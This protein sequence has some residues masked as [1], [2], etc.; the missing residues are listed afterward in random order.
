MK[1]KIHRLLT[2]PLLGFM[3]LC[4]CHPERPVNDSF[5]DQVLLVENNP[6]LYLAKVDTTK[7]ASVSNEQEAT[8]FLLTALAQNYLNRD[9]YP[10]KDKLIASIR[11]FEKQKLAQQQLEALFLLAP[12]YKRENDLTNEVHTIE[13]AIR[14][15]REEDDQ[16]WLF[17]LY[18]YLGDMYIRQYN[19]LKFVKY[20]TLAN[21][22]IKDI[23]FPD[24]SLATQV[25]VA[26]SLLYLEQYPKAYERLQ[27]IE[28][29]IGKNN[30][31]F[32]DIK[33]LQGI[34]LFQMH[35][36]DACIKD[37]ETSLAGERSAENKFTCH[38][39]LTYCHYLKGDREQA[40]KHKQLAM[41]YDADNGT[42]FTQI[43]FYTLCAE[44]AR[45]NHPPRKN[46]WPACIG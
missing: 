27:E 34:A 14:I 2:M 26:K 45:T 6:Q 38:S 3:L 31:Y 12:I 5:D 13:N 19:T 10:P 28:S 4:S 22:C 32:Q 21:Q 18:S 24:M 15:A 16:E 25:Q 1:D 7:P 36:W 39:L 23:P 35:Q 30:I 20:Q 9:C 42:G 17:Y 40:E 41:E 44:F 43:E 33:R 37:L 29:G 46:N 11:L 8:Q